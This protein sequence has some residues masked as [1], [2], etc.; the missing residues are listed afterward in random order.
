MLSLTP[1]S[2]RCVSLAVLMAASAFAWAQPFGYSINSRGNS[3]DDS[4]VFALWRI[5]LATGE[6]TYVGW[7]GRG[8]FIDIEGVAFREDGRLYGADDNTHSLLLIGIETGNAVPVGGSRSNMGVRIGTSMDF[9]MTFTCEGQLLVSSAGTESL[10]DADPATGRLELIGELGLP[11]VDLAVIGRDIFGIGLGTDE[12]GNSAYPNL[13]RIDPE[14]PS[15]ELI[16]PLGP[17]VSPYI[18]AGLS[19]DAEGRL[20][21][22]TD[23]NSVPPSVEALPSQILRIDPET[24]MA[25]RIAET[26]VGIESLAITTPGS[27]D[28]A[29][30]SSIPA[31][32]PALSPA[33][34]A[35]LIAALVALALVQLRGRFPN[36]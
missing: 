32:I 11:I 9:G 8:D 5:D 28:R 29:A 30:H 2:V 33:M 7:T 26:I 17:A 3:T 12:S 16:G 31:E 27:C 4:E 34:R 24:G 19:A 25:E 35:L 6:E 15:A 13:Y 21:A 23:R 10:Y 1:L 18:Q 36:C 14:A 22:V 20:W